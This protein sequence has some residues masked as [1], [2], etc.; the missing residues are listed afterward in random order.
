MRHALDD[1][2]E[3]SPH[4][5]LLE[6]AA[7]LARGVRRLRARPGPVEQASGVHA[8]TSDRTAEPGPVPR[9]CGGTCVK[10]AEIPADSRQTG[11][12]LSASSRPDRP[13]C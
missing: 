7:I 10:S 13:V 9:D 4:Q 11:L 2:A 6:I 1:P 3:L 12:E 5:R 8:A